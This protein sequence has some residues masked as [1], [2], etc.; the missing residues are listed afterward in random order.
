MLQLPLQ[1]HGQQGTYWLLHIV[2]RNAQ[3]MLQSP[4]VTKLHK[5]LAKVK[6]DLTVYELSSEQRAFQIAER[7]FIN[8]QRKAFQ[9]KC[10]TFPSTDPLDAENVAA[11][12][13]EFK[14]LEIL[15][16]YAYDMFLRLL[17]YISYWSQK[18]VKEQD[19]A[20][21]FKFAE[22]QSQSLLVFE[23]WKAI[24]SNKDYGPKK[25]K[26]HEILDSIKGRKKVVFCWDEA[27][28]LFVEERVDWSHAMVFRAVR[29]AACRIAWE[30]GGKG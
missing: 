18:G 5:K 28:G 1:C 29:R 7:T 10:Q 8:Q 14:V 2:C 9:S 25:K 24:L 16:Q 21:R 27:C 17:C 26:P 12:S 4:V 22:T 11:D 19:L 30:L 3:A 20:A 23:E 15:T 6:D 13:E